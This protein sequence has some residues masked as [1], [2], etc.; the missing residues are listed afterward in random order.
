[1]LFVSDG[2]ARQ[3]VRRETYDD[4]LACDLG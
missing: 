1:V 4:L 2:T 3:V